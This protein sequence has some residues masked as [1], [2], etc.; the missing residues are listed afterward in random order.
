[1]PHVCVCV[2]CRAGTTND[3]RRTTDD[4]C[5]A[6]VSASQPASQPASSVSESGA[7]NSFSWNARNERTKRTNERVRGAGENRVP[8]PDLEPSIQPPASP[9]RSTRP[10]SSA[11]WLLAGWAPEWHRCDRPTATH[12]IFLF[13]YFIIISKIVLYHIARIVSYRIVPQSFDTQPTADSDLD[14]NTLCCVSCGVVSHHPGAISRVRVRVRVRVRTA[15]SV[16]AWSPRPLL[17]PPLVLATPALRTARACIQLPNSFYIPAQMNRRRST[18]SAQTRLVLTPS[19]IPSS[20][21][22]SPLTI[23]ITINNE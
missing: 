8:A 12:P 5:I 7:R 13:S 15:Y 21:H 19:H 17:S 18:E 16:P 3:G 1:M 14:T 9:C 22:P 20:T 11:R 2:W 4:G 10:D 23:T 6:P